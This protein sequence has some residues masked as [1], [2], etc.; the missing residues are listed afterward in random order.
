MILDEFYKLSSTRGDNRSNILNNAFLKVM[1]SKQCQFYLLGPNIDSVSDE[2]LKKYNAKF[3]K[4]RYT[5]VNTN[6][7]DK[8]DHVKSLKQ[9]FRKKIYLIY[10]IIYQ[11]K[12]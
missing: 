8:Y 7:F 11:N 3:F 2:F 12:L 1:K 9:K 4:T 5:L 6:V 10:W